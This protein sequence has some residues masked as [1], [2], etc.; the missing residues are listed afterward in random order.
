MFPGLELLSGIKF[1]WLQTDAKIAVE[2]AANISSLKQSCR[3]IISPD[4]ESLERDHP[5]CPVCRFDIKEIGVP[6]CITEHQS[7]T[8]M[9]LCV[10]LAEGQI[11]D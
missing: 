1:F 11:P 3:E 6:Q 9:G 4:H 5:A 2:Q 7:D 8:S 10:H